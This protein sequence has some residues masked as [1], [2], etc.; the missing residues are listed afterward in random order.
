MTSSSSRV[1]ISRPLSIL[2][3]IVVVVAWVGYP[4]L[5]FAEK[6]KRVVVL[7]FEGPKAAKFQKGVIKLIKKSHTVVPLDEW[8]GTADELGATDMTDKNVKKVAKK[9]KVDAVVHGKIEKRRD[10]YLIQIKLRSGKSG[11]VV[12]TRID[13]KAD[14]PK[15]AGQ[16]SKDLKTELVAAITDIKSAK[17]A[18]D[19]EEVAEAD[20]EEEEPVGKGKKGKKGK[21]DEAVEEEAGDEQPKGK[22]FSKRDQDAEGGDKVGDE[23]GGDDESAEGKEVASKEEDEKQEDGGSVEKEAAPGTPVANPMSPGERA[24]DLLAGVSFNARKMKFSY[25]GLM[26]TEAPP[27]Y[28]GV[29]VAGLLIDATVYPLAIGHTRKGMMKNLGLTLMYD[30]VIKI[31]SK[32]NGMTLPTTQQ[33][34]AVGAAFRYPFNDSAT[35]PVAGLIVRYG[36]QSFQITGMSGIPNVNYTIIDPIAFFKYPLSTKMVVGVNLGY[37]LIS[38]AGQI[39]NAQNYG[40][41]GVSGFEGELSLDYFFTKNIYAHAAFRFETIAFSFP[42]SGMLSSMRDGDP[43]QDVFGARDSYYGGAVTAGYAF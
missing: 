26:A 37:L 42:A 16:A 15:I 4:E 1:S 14:G 25:T 27:P 11:A 9:L 38:N 39:Q 7:D 12:G 22:K 41:G 24:V 36:R 34:Y 13:T 23:E 30:R 20:T 21:G 32:A 31:E 28:N 10:S 5:A 2:L 6:K 19:E 18:K 29:P 33:R 40:K 3:A 8:N 43:E 17:K 35:A